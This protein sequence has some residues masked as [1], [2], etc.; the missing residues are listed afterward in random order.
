MKSDFEKKNKFFSETLEELKGNIISIKS[1]FDIKKENFKKDEI[2][3]KNMIQNQE[4]KIDESQDKNMFQSFENLL[5]TI[6]TQG[7][8]DNKNYE[9]LKI[10]SEKLI[11][12]NMSP[13]DIINR[14]FVELYKLQNFDDAEST[15]KLCE[16][17]MK[18]SDIILKINKELK[19]KENFVQNQ[20]QKK[21]PKKDKKADKKIENFRKKFGLSEEDASDD[22]IREYLKKY[23]NKENETY[24][25]LMI[26]IV[27]GKNK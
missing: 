9:K 12:N 21:N 11:K 18:L 2:K 25:A 8:I 13:C 19:K 4:L 16:L 15:K 14:Y 24:Q 6:V 3:E 10:L 1:K 20:N 22:K 27:N 17:N 5:A 7:D 26:S 23:K